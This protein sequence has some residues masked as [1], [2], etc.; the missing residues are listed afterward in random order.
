MS[1][2]VVIAAG[3]VRLRKAVGALWLARRGGSRGAE[4]S[5]V[6]YQDGIGAMLF[7][8]LLSGAVELVLADLL[9]SVLWMRV[10]A[11]T[12]GVL[13]VFGMLSFIVALRVYPH[14]AVNGKLTIHY[15]ACFDLSVPLELV[16][17]VTRQLT[18][19]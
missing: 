4:A 10:L 1:E 16:A 8:V 9:L 17:V 7:V 18:C 5:S 19:P 11:L 2:S 3:G 13:A 6:A 15:G 14:R 12:L